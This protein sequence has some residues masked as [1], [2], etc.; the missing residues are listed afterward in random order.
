MKTMRVALDTN[1][2]VYAEGLNGPAK[3]Q[4]AIDLLEKLPQ[5]LIVTPA[6]T[7]GELFN[8]LVKKARRSPAEARAAILSWHDSYEVAD[9]SVK[10]IIAATDLASQHQLGIWDAVVLATAADAG[11][12]LLLTE[13]MQNG[14]TWN[15]ITV[16]NPFA[17][18][19][20]PLLDAI[21]QSKS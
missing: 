11:C 18:V 21:L 19:L 5:D 13:D 12:R 2:M 7:L 3:M 6:Q 20:H 16:A 9:T 10:V 8:V 14:F 15:G 1:I 17:T 4:E